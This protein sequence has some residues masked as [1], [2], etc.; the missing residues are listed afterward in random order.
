MLGETEMKKTANELKIAGQR[1][2]ERKPKQS[3]F[4]EMSVVFSLLRQP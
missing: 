1:L 4:S 3:V 2:T